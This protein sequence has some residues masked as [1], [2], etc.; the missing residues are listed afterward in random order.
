MEF[1]FALNLFIDLCFVLDIA[2]SFRSSFIHPITGDEIT[3]TRL[4][5]I[6]YLSGRFLLDLLA[7][8]PFDILLSLF[9]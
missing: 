3:D 2:I 5:A 7:A 1:F 8:L 6:H 9:L 4:I